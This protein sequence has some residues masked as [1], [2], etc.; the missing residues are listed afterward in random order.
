MVLKLLHDIYGQK[1]CPKVCGDFLHEGLMKPNVQQSQVNPCLYYR[2]GLVFLIYIDDCLLLG[3]SD[4]LIDQA[5]KD[6]QAAE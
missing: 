5:I 2:P 1:Q 6:L 3:P 4:D